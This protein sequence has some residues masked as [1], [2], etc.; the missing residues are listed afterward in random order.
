[1]RRLV[2]VSSIFLELF[3]DMEYYLENER[4]LLDGNVLYTRQDNLCPSVTHHTAYV[5][6]YGY[7]V[8]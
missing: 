5:K 6:L 8:C 2:K 4:N 7:R 1:M 3:K